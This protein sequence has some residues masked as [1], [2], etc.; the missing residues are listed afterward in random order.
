MFF[1]IVPTISRYSQHEKFRM[2]M[3]L[4]CFEMNIILIWRIVIDLWRKSNMKL[5]DRPYMYH[6]L[7]RELALCFKS[8]ITM[9]LEFLWIGAELSCRFWSLQNVI[10]LSPPSI[11]QLEYCHT[12]LFITS[13]VFVS[14]KQISILLTNT[15]KF[16]HGGCGDFGRT[17]L[18]C[19]YF[20]TS[21]Y[22]E[23]S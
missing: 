5:C 8:W 17:R 6:S 12:Y 14:D 15:W 1:I 7:A 20:A 18:Q 3:V 21:K 19:V 2:K 16:I 9:L 23:K 22:W 10:S 11:S 4:T 13:V